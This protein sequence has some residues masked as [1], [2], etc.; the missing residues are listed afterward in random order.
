MKKSQV[1]EPTATVELTAFDSLSAGVSFGT[2][3]VVKGDID[4]PKLE[5]ALA[6]VV[7]KWRLFA[8]RIQRQ[9]GSWVVKVPLGPL[10][11]DYAP[12]SITT[13]TNDRP[14]SAYVS[15]PLASVSPA[16]PPEIYMP[17][18]LPT[19]NEEYMLL[20]HPLASFH[21]VKF[22]PE[23]PT[24]A[25]YSSIGLTLPHGLVDGVGAAFLCKAIVAELNGEDWKVPPL[26]KEG[27]NVNGLQTALQ[28]QDFTRKI[29]PPKITPKPTKL[30]FNKT[31]ANNADAICA[32]GCNENVTRAARIVVIPPLVFKS[33]VEDVKSD[34]HDIT[35]GDVLVSWILKTMYE[36]D[37]VPSKKIMIQSLASF[38]HLFPSLSKFNMAD[39]PHN[40]L[41]LLPIPLIPVWYIQEKTISEL[42]AFMSL[43]RRS[44]SEYDVS[45]F[46]KQ[47]S[48]LVPITPPSSES[49]PID[50]EPV[51]LVISNASKWRLIEMDWSKI[52]AE[53]TFCG[54]RMLHGYERAGKDAIQMIG[55]LDDGSV[56][57]DTVLSA[58]HA[59]RFEES[60]RTLVAKYT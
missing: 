26:P 40:Y 32:E 44:F 49:E 57:L 31:H 39:S 37:P 7:D 53:K 1:P 45:L 55:R 46:L 12:Y 20:S 22:A 11:F 9:G 35:T 13:A 58:V 21:I 4:L 41:S 59:R 30:G 16:L 54:Y 47:V 29:C 24:S 36:S 48:G 18:F 6:R 8:G 23:S 25:P 5:Q 51:P 33:F 19:S 2:A 3:W 60:V 56:V 10:P 38:R 14:L 50:S 52:G 42:S 43:C 17:S 28:S 34:N 15:L 27:F